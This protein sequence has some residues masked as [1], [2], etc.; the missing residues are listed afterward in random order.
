MKALNELIYI[1]V[2]SLLFAW[3]IIFASVLLMFLRV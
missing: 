1:H 3:F 2:L